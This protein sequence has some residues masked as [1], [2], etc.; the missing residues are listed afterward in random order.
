MKRFQECSKIE[1]I[2]RYRWYLLI[3]FQYVYYT[4]FKPFKVYIDDWEG[5]KIVHTNEYDVMKGKMLW[6]LLKGI[7][8]EK[9]VWY[10]TS[11]EVLE[12]INNIKTNKYV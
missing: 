2:W 8:Q 3:P 7:A 11:E 6:K 5:D 4:Y 12:R 1:Q 10:Y 9:M